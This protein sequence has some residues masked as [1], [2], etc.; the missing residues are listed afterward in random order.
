MGSSWGWVRVLADQTNV[1]AEKE[2]IDEAGLTIGATKSTIVLNLGS[3]HR[4]R[5][6]AILEL[7]VARFPEGNS[8][9]LPDPRTFPSGVTGCRLSSS[10]LALHGN[11]V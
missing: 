2:V 9:T 4:L 3:P 5:K 7:L 10:P 11:I 1:R 6:N 8:L